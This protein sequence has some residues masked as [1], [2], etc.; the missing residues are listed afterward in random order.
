[1]GGSTYRTKGKQYTPAVD[2]RDKDDILNTW[3]T[4]MDMEVPDDQKL[5][6]CEFFYSYAEQHG[7][8]LFGIIPYLYYRR[9]YVPSKEC[10]FTLWKEF[11][12]LRKDE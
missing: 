9:G 11:E 1:M 4:H 3:L 7:Y 2:I 8:E 5:A 12:K 6:F 10:Q